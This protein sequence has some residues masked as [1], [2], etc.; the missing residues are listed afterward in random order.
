[1]G[2]LVGA[3]IARLLPPRSEV[4][5][6]QFT[7]SPLALVQEMGTCARLILIDAVSTGR[8]PVGSV[9]LFTEEDLSLGK[10]DLF[11]HG[12]NLPAVFS[13]ARQA[14]IPMPRWIRLVGIEVGSIQEFGEVPEPE[15]ALRLDAIVRNALHIVE[16]LLTGA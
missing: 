7:G 11:P 5:V 1:V 13:L 4:A 9:L 16:R 10:G 12:M 15:I 2:L 6:R 3:R 14:G 8:W